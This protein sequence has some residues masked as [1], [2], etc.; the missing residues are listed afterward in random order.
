VSAT[1]DQSSHGKQ[2]ITRHKSPKS[3][4]KSMSA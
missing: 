3:L 4:L 2:Q 1:A